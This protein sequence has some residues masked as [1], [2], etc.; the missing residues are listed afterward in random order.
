MES[1]ADR[2]D[3]R[4]RGPNTEQY[5]NTTFERTEPVDFGSVPETDEQVGVPPRLRE[6]QT[7]ADR[8]AL[9]RHPGR[10]GELRRRQHHVLA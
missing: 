8:R 10:A 9:G 7:A 6:R 1:E 3:S 2:R 5:V 4:F